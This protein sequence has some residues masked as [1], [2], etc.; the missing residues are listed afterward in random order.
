MSAKLEVV[1]VDQGDALPPAT[2]SGQ[3]AATPTAT[4]PSAAGLADTLPNIPAFRT[5]LTELPGPRKRW[6]GEPAPESDSRQAQKPAEPTGPLIPKELAGAAT[7]AAEALGVGGLVKHAFSL[8]DAFQGLQRKVER[9]DVSGPPAGR[10]DVPSGPARDPVTIDDIG[11]HANIF[12]DPR[13]GLADAIG[14]SSEKDFGQAVKMFGASAD[15]AALAGIKP[16]V[17]VSG[18]AAGAAAG[19]GRTV[20]AG[21]AGAAGAG[22]GGAAGGV[23]ALAAVAGPAAVAVV[24]A[25]AAITGLAVAV[26]KTISALTSEA[27]RLQDY[28]GDVALSVARSEIRA[29]MADI[30]RAERIGPNLAKF[31]NLRGRAE[32]KLADVM[33]EV[34]DL[35]TKLVEDFE[36]ILNRGIMAAEYGAANAAV[37]SAAIATASDLAMGRADDLGKDAKALSDANIRLG[38]ALFKL[39]GF[40]EDEEEDAEDP[41]LAAFL[42]RWGAEPAVGD[43][44]PGRGLPGAPAGDGVPA[45]F[46]PG[47]AFGV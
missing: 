43:P 7:M 20:A 28:S 23:G 14:P 36:P 40:L 25:T 35:L 27:E 26:K 11:S 12:G 39:L 15:D 17:P 32:E 3:G 2:P 22:A 19:A 8:A 13:D 47:G 41:I 31:E 29:E 5:P 9:T 16:T 6:K 33:T 24:A 38:K 30:R 10:S 44:L 42:A 18:A 4:P 34:Y 21:A 46:K 45:S 37:L 1:I